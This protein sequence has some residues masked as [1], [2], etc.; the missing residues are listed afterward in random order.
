MK[1]FFMSDGASRRAR[2]LCLINVHWN[3]EYF[4]HASSDTSR[5]F[6]S[7]ER[8]CSR[9]CVY[10]RLPIAPLDYKELQLII[11]RLM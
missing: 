11:E 6:D 4:R 7:G 5:L 8:I 3:P 1:T 10:V 2:F 9:F